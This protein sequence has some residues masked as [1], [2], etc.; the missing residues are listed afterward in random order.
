M[1]K[2]KPLTSLKIAGIVLLNLIIQSCHSQ[3]FDLATLKLPVPESSITSKFKLEDDKFLVANLSQYSSLEK[4]ALYFGGK[5]LYGSIDNSPTTSYLANGV[6]FFIDQKTKQ[7]EAYRLGIKTTAETEKLVKVLEAKLGKTFYYY[8]DPDMSFRIWELNGITYFLEVNST[9]VYNGEHTVSSD[10]HVVNNKA[11]TFYNYIMAGGFG[12]Y[13]DY[14]N[15]KKKSTKKVYTY[16]DFLNEMKAEGS[17]YY[18]KKL[19][20]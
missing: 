18:L 2:N 19:V 4:E 1:T 5:S 6:K 14:L 8:K 16:N 13:A 20:R 11:E 12:Y 10:L 9:T 15:A 3:N 7:I 17:D